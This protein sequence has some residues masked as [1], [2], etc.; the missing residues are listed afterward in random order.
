MSL[1][2]IACLCT[3]VFSF[4]IPILIGLYLLF[5]HQDDR[6]RRMAGLFTL[7]PFA[8]TPVWVSLITSGADRVVSGTWISTLVAALLTGL[9]VSYFRDLFSNPL[10]GSPARLLVGLDCLRW[11]NTFILVNLLAVS[12]NG[13][14][15]LGVA[16]LASILCGLL[17]PGI[18][19]LVA[20]N[21]T[22][23]SRDGSAFDDEPKKKTSVA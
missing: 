5:T 19:A 7:K 10:T 3:P 2:E 23:D 21:I 8:T 18:F 11:L 16:A 6:L 13:S 12:N 4:L 9:L 22:K 20:F 15:L 14:S 17:L 1:Y